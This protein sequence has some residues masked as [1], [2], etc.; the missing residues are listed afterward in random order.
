MSDVLRGG[1]VSW[2]EKYVFLPIYFL[3]NTYIAPQN[4][5]NLGL[6]EVH[7]MSGMEEGRKLQ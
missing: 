3:L 1:K 2:Q 7:K 4:L 6:G 5:A